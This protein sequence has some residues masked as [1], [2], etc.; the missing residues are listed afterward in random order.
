MGTPAPC[1][2]EKQII[3]SKRQEESHISWIQGVTPHT[4][5]K[6]V[7]LPKPWS[8]SAIHLFRHEERRKRLV[9]QSLLYAEAC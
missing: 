1:F 6:A 4:H 8:Q 3:S 5:T 2:F 7:F 9:D